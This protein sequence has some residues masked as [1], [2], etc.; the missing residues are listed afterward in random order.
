M[1]VLRSSVV[2][3]ALRLRELGR[4]VGRLMG[5]ACALLGGCAQPVSQTGNDVTAP[6]GG[7]LSAQLVPGPWG[8]PLAVMQAAGSTSVQEPS[9]KQ[10][11]SG[12]FEPP[13]DGVA[14]K[15]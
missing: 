12:W 1:I 15:F 8:V 3:R 5:L 7:Q 4:L 6:G 2:P 10:Q 11:A 14:T 13:G 9:G